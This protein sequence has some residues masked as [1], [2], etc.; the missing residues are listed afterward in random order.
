[1]TENV[2]NIESYDRLHWLW[3]AAGFI[4]LPFTIVQT[5]IPI[6]AWLAP[7]FLL[8]F[9]RTSKRAW[10]AILPVFIAYAAGIC[11]AIRSI[12]LSNIKLFIL[13]IIIF[14]VMKGLLFTLP[15][16]A[17]SIIGRRLG[18]WVRV[19]VFPMAFAAS[20]WLMSLIRIV[21]STGSPAYTQ[22]DNLALMQILSV[23]GMW[24][25]T[26]ILAWFA[27]TVNALW[28]N[29]FDLKPVRGIAVT[30]TAVLFAVLIYG[31]LRLNFFVPSPPVVEA[32]AITIDSSVSL[33][34]RSGIDWLTFNQSAD[35]QRA[36]VRPQFKAGLVE[37]LARTETALRAGAKIVAWEEGAVTILEEDK[38]N[39]LAQAAVLAREYDACL[40]ISLGVATR[41]SAQQFIRNQSILIDNTGGLRWTYD[42]TYPVFPIESY[43]EIAGNGK[44]PV[45]G[46]AYGR[47]CTSICND[48]HF[49]PLIRQAGENNA[50]ILLAPYSD[51]HP[52]EWEDAVTATYRA[53][54]NGFSL[55]RPAGYGIS[56]IADY[57]GRIIASRNYFT[58]SRGI[59]LAAVP[60]HGVTTV[61]SR[62]GDIFAYLCAG[63]LAFLV[64]LSQ[65]RRER[66]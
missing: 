45:T 44:L 14:P 47:L 52:Y 64:I 61:Y 46:S 28:E 18:S 27:S 3:L 58:D 54:E 51:I 12:D 53:V 26:F 10:T 62:I 16:A 33:K 15:Y 21:N 8:R 40:E 50:D 22:F 7:V 1:M 42:K 9:V 4:L 2:N 5:V 38:D 13:G 34:A 23:T 24:G 55:V 66:A 48:L 25:I 31:S 43:Y 11:I 56:T 57:K 65:F 41:T 6:A 49:P 35:A 60:I 63:G 37:M 59:M 17:D 36:A 32:A 29:G 19:L 20:D 30:F 39:A